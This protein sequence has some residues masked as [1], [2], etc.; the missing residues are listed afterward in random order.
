MTVLNELDI[1]KIDV[2][3]LALSQRPN[4]IEHFSFEHLKPLWWELEREVSRGRIGALG[5]CD[6]DKTMLE[7]LYNWA[8]V[9][10]HTVLSFFFSPLFFCYI[11]PPPIL[12]FI[13]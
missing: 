12:L 13:V 9:S 7:E 3:L 5:I 4:V 2:V 6:A 11:P 8:R 10:L 1:S